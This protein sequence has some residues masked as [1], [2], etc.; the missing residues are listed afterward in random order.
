MTPRQR[1]EYCQ[2][3]GSHNTALA[4]FRQELPF[5]VKELHDIVLSSSRPQPSQDPELLHLQKLQSKACASMSTSSRF[6]L[7]KNP[8]NT[9][10][11]ASERHPALE[12]PTTNQIDQPIL[13][14]LTTN[15]APVLDYPIWFSIQHANNFVSHVCLIQ[16]AICL[17]SAG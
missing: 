16:K 3:P 9:I 15:K 6:D 1:Y 17:P 7:N 11:L 2:P 4:V 8:L 5:K 13:G 10:P 14:E 12:E